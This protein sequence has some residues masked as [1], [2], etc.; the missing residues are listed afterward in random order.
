VALAF[1]GKNF[2]L[3][4]GEKGEAS[5]EIEKLGHHHVVKRADDFHVDKKNKI[6]T[7]PA[8]MYD[9]APLHEIF[10]GIQKLVK[11]VVSLS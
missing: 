5:Q 6:V 2:E 8:Y 4:V 3:T 9:D 1:K 11:E 10:M 7:T